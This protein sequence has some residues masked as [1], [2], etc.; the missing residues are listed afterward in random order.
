MEKAAKDKLGAL[1]GT[2][3]A[4]V[5]ETPQRESKSADFERADQ[6]ARADLAERGFPTRH[7]R[8]LDRMTGPSLRR[9][10]EL[11]PRIREGDCLLVLCGDRG[12][13]KTQM[14]TFWG[15]E[16]RSARYY[17]AHDLMEAIRRAFRDDG[18]EQAAADLAI[19]RARKVPFLVIDE[20]SELS[21][22]AFERR[23]LTNILDHRYDALLATVIITNH[24]EEAAA[25]AI[26]RSIWSRAQ[27]TGGVVNC[28]WPSYR[29]KPC[30]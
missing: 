20:F 25:E 5:V 18:K 7:L 8:N 12:P 22:S 16:I 19:R 15:W 4:N 3:E 1:M 14:A 9:A 27:E 6:R 21:G 30:S 26:G 2:L 17:K 28:D 13:G 24:A 10:Q 29:R 11:T 23:T